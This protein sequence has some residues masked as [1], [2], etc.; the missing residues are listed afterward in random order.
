M[1][2]KTE[3]L[4]IAGTS[5]SSRAADVI[6][7]HGLDGDKQLTWQYEDYEDSFWPRL[8]YNDIPTCG[9]WSFGFDARSSEWIHGGTMPIVDRATNFAGFLKSEGI[10][11]KPI[12]FIVHSLGGLVVKQVLRA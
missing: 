7:V 1:A 4:S 3:L 5:S 11:D 12:F 9:V 10:G 6:F 8:L 2:V